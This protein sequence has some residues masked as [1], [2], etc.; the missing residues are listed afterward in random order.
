MPEIPRDQ[1]EHPMMMRR[2]HDDAARQRAVRTLRQKLLPALAA[3]SRE[4]WYRSVEPRWRAAH[5]GRTAEDWRE[6]RDAMTARPYVQFQ[7][8]THRVIQ[9]L[10]YETLVDTVEPQREALARQARE[11]S[12]G[13]GGGI[14]RGSLRLDPGFRVPRYITAVDIHCQPGGYAHEGFEGDVAAG[15]VYDRSINMYQ[16]GA[17]GMTDYMGRTVCGYL[18]KVWP[19]FRPRRILDMGCTVG[20]S[21]LAYARAFPDAEVYAI[22]V[23]APLLRY[24]HAR[25]TALGFA[26]HFSQQNAE[27]TDF[28]DGHFDLVVSHILA[29]ETAAHAWPAILKEAR[30]LLA[31]GGI[32]VHV[33]L[34][35]FAEIDPYRRFIYSNE[36]DFNNEPFWTPYRLMNLHALMRDAGFAEDEIYRDFSAVMAGRDRAAAQAAIERSRGLGHGAPPGSGL[37]FAMLVGTRGTPGAAAGASAAPAGSHP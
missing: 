6:I 16:S 33:D 4:T 36:T 35:Q 34:P 15:A 13:A 28:P 11:L 14:V 32:T 31:P 24:A 2:A 25:A 19:S 21:T 29:H 26:V 5:D 30:R 37:G 8:G 10:M 23:A 12:A 3:G 18:Q 20:H 17:G 27:H 22:D 7:L 9:E 1:V